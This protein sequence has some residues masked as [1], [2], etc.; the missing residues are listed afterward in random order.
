MAASRQ[1]RHELLKLPSAGLLMLLA[2]LI[3]LPQAAA[4]AVLLDRFPAENEVLTAGPGEVRLRFNE[5]V[6]PVLVRVLD[7][8]GKPVAGPDA[9]S[10]RDASVHVRLPDSLPVEIYK[11]GNGLAY[12]SSYLGGAINFVTPTAHTAVAP[13]ILRLEGGSFNTGRINLQE[14]RVL[15]DF[16]FLVNNTATYA[17][18]GANPRSG[19][20][21]SRERKFRCLPT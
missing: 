3:D 15:G 16:D 13:N 6:T 4:H 21:G 9:V 8:S 2:L 17:T 14:S 18:G 11:G 20:C 19:C 12:G 1:A 10:A 7:Q 5:P